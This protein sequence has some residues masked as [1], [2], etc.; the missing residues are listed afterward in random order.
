MKHALFKLHPHT[1]LQK[2]LQELKALGL[3]E[4]YLIQDSQETLIG[5]LLDK[6]PLTSFSSLLQ[7]DSAIDWEHQYKLHAPYY[8]DGLLQVPLRDFG[9]PFD[10]T[11]KL[12]PGPGFGDLS[13]PTT[14]LTL[15]ELAPKAQGA[16]VLDIGCGSGILA[17]A[18]QKLGTSRALGVDIDPQALA[19]AQEN[20]LLNQA[21]RHATFSSS[22]DP[23][24]LS[25]GF[26]IVCLNMLW[27]EQI[28]VFASYPSLD[29]KGI[30]IVSGLLEEQK[31]SYLASFPYA[32]FKLINSSSKE[33]WACLTL[34]C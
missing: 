33:G 18:A 12:L 11:L 31:A 15:Q 24:I 5:G 20:A 14:Y 26:W 17:L 10:T 21:S 32:G 3:Q 34:F 1:S 2:A 4:H 8:K 16:Q 9:A 25:E 6:P 7:W 19:H 28:E 13:H 23:K 30:F 22:F 27:Q 29:F